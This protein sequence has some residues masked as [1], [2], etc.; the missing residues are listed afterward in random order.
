M[1]PACAT[2]DGEGEVSVPV[3][4]FVS[5]VVPCPDCQSEEIEVGGS[6]GCIDSAFET[7]YE[8]EHSAKADERNRIRTE[9]IDWLVGTILPCDA[10]LI[11]GRRIVDEIDRICPKE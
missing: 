1:I 10:G 3:T 4:A 2:C 9:L 5:E 6:D 11:N 8:L 7:E